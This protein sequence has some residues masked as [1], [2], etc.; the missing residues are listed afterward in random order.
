MNDQLPKRRLLDIQETADYLHLK[1]KQ[2]LYNWIQQRKGPNYLKIG[3]RLMWELSEL[4]R[5]IDS[6]R[7]IL[8]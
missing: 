3:R 5:F 1:N 7:V 4:D 2:T 6:N 8:N